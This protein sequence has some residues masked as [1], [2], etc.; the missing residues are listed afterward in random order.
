VVRALARYGL[1]IR[2]P[3]QELAD[4]LAGGPANLADARHALAN[5]D[6]PWQPN[7]RGPHHRGRLK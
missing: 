6:P 2:T 4:D 5:D 3:L 1:V 7:A